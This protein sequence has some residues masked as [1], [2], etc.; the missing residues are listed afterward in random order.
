MRVQKCRRFHSDKKSR[1]A[2]K[3][4]PPSRQLESFNEASN[5]LGLVIYES[6]R[7]IYITGSSYLRYGQHLSFAHSGSS[8]RRLPPLSG[9]EIAPDEGL[10]PAM[11]SYAMILQF[12]I[13]ETEVVACFIQKQA[14]SSTLLSVY[15]YARLA[16]E[17]Y[18]RAHGNCAFNPM[19]LSTGVTAFQDHRA[20]HLITASGEIQRISLGDE[21]KF[22]DAPDTP[23]E[24]PSHAISLSRDGSRWASIYYGRDKAQVQA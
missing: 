4:V 17:V 21:I 19:L 3:E 5:R 9:P 6:N 15:H 24:Y 2:S 20:A 11:M 22:L 8:G 16:S 18:V 7:H 12:P 14:H 13:D 10:P 1:S 23:N